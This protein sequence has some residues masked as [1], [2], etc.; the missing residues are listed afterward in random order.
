MRKILLVLVVLMVVFGM[1]GCNSGTHEPNNNKNYFVKDGGGGGDTEGEFPAGYIDLSGTTLTLAD[2]FQYG[3]GY[4]GI[5]AGKLSGAIEEGKAWNFA[6]AFTVDRDLEDLM[7]IE[8]VD[9]RSGATPSAY[10]SKRSATLD[11]S[12]AGGIKKGV[13]YVIGERFSI[14]N[15]GNS[16]D[17]SVIDIC[18]QTEGDGDGKSKHPGADGTA[19][20]GVKG[21]AVISFV[22]FI[23]APFV[24]VPPAP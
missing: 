20:S 19:G 15:V 13:V 8:L 4:Q 17:L 7:Q 12:P 5:I 11:F 21:P 3:D 14:T 24:V 16:P 23:I 9:R 6:I 10:W 22:E 18:F 1:F 2:N